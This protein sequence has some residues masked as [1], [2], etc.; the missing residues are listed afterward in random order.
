M[1]PAG[2]P[3]ISALVGGSHSHRETLLAAEQ[4]VPPAVS[5]R[6]LIDTGASHTCVDSSVL[7]ALQL[8][9]IETIVMQTAS[10]GVA[11]HTTQ[12][13]EV[14]LVAPGAARQDVPL[15]LSNTSVIATELGR[16]GFQALI[17]RD[18]MLLYN[19]SYGHFSL[20]F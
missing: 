20:A 18:C 12:E 10:T 11:S 17:G 9:P 2:R 3:I 13:Y 4:P 16:S 5:I 1:D 8:D 14:S 19:G 15:T 7:R 6:A